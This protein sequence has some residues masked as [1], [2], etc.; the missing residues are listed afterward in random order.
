L[1]VLNKLNCVRIPNEDNFNCAG[2]FKLG[3]GSFGSFFASITSTPLHLYYW[4]LICL[5]EALQR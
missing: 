5:P 3:I 4:Q 1:L 2:R